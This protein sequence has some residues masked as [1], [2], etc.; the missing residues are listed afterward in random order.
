MSD[1]S[2]REY[3]GITTVVAAHEG[4][5]GVTLNGNHSN[6][7]WIML[8]N[9]DIMLGIFPQGETYEDSWHG[10]GPKEV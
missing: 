4:A 2:S 1:V 6:W 5:V 8:P 3:K 7:C 9:G 10:Y